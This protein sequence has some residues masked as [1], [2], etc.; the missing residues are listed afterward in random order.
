[1]V[2]L[3]KGGEDSWQHYAQGGVFPSGPPYFC[4][5][6]GRLYFSSPETGNGDI[7]SMELSR[8]FIKRITSSAACDMAP[9]VDCDSKRIFFSREAE[10]TRHIWAM[11]LDSLQQ[12]RLTSGRYLDDLTAISADGK[13]LLFSRSPLTLGMGKSV[14]FYLLDVKI[15][16]SIPVAIGKA[17]S[18]APLGDAIV[19]NPSN[20]FDE[21]WLRNFTDNQDFHVGNG[22]LPHVSADLSKV[23]AIR[24]PSG[25]IRENDFDIALIDRS[26]HTDQIL[27]Q[28]HAPRFMPDG[29]GVVFLK[30]YSDD[31]YFISTNRAQ[32][33][34]VNLPRGPKTPPLLSAERRMCIITTLPSGPIGNAPP[35]PQLAFLINT[36]DWTFAAVQLGIKGGKNIN[37]QEVKDTR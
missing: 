6:D 14:S 33:V 34:R 29:S 2:V 17:A 4:P 22:R 21:I 5:K 37:S 9:L 25:G 11:D 19:Y 3:S 16:N 13:H 12:I 20:A 28:G 8:Y 1:M 27:A 18:F 15:A 7:Y 10:G 23:L 24:V 36:D 35:V 31:L 26:K 32:T 30:G